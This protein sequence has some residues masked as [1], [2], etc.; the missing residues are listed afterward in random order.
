MKNSKVCFLHSFSENN[1][2][3]DLNEFSEFKYGNTNSAKNM[4]RNLYEKFTT[5]YSD[6]I[7]DKNIILFSSPYDKIPTS[8]YFLTNYFFDLF[9]KDQNSKIKSVNLG[10]IFRM[11]TY[12]NDYSKMSASD[13]YKLISQDTYSFDSKPNDDS[14]LIFIDDISITGTHQIV[15]EEL[16]N[17]NTIKNDFMF[18]YYAKLNDLN[19]SPSIESRINNYKINSSE[20]LLKLIFSPNFKFTTRTIK[21]ILLLEEQ[22]FELFIDKIFLHNQGMLSLVYNL[23]ISNKYDKIDEFID[24]IT[25]LKYKVNDMVS[26]LNIINQ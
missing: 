3:F 25:I 8:C 7:E 23:A 19:C 2:P 10:K 12:P 1:I 5:I 21:Y 24:N 20:E 18:L 15:I 16:L 26:N 6:Y 14:F 9:L 4:A 13:R 17:S 11:N 22:E